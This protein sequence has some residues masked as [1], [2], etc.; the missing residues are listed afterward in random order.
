[1]FDLASFNVDLVNRFPYVGFLKD[2]SI[3]VPE[4]KSCLN[5]YNST[6]EKLGLEHIKKMDLE[7][8]DNST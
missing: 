8:S 7:N 1:M 4:M 6:F 3:P 2:V 5:D